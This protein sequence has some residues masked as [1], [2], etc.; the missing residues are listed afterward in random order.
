MAVAPPPPEDLKFL[1]RIHDD[2]DRGFHYG[3]PA[4]QTL[5]EEP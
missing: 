1:S 3:S 4:V 5:R 2:I